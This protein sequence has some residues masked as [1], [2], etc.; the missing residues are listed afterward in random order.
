MVITGTPVLRRQACPSAA[1]CAG[2]P[3]SA[4]SANR[5]G[6]RLASR[7][8]SSSQAP[9]PERTWKGYLKGPNCTARSKV[10]A[11]VVPA[12]ML[13]LVGDSPARHMGRPRGGA[14]GRQRPCTHAAPALRPCGLAAARCRGLRVNRFTCRSVRYTYRPS[15]GKGG[16]KLMGLHAAGTFSPDPGPHGRERRSRPLKRQPMAL[17][18]KPAH[19]VSGTGG[20]SWFE[21]ASAAGCR[22]EEVTA[23]PAAG[24]EAPGGPG[25]K[26]PPAPRN[27]RAAE[28]KCPVA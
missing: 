13:L 2:T 24:D 17:G 4:T 22:D 20:R 7:R 12:S 10:T 18:E 27:R 3:S 25:S 1:R 19:G 6:Q 26:S 9:E 28:G 14:A 5:S 21:R 8:A 23:G 11:V 15:H 16:V